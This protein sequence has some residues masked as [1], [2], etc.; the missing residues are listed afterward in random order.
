MHDAL[1]KRHL[2]FLRDDMLEHNLRR[3]IEP[4][5]CVD[6]TFVAKQISMELDRVEAKLAEM[7]LD[8]KLSGTLDQG[9]GTLIVF[10]EPAADDAYTSGLEAVSK[11]NGVVDQLMKRAEGLR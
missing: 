2:G 11:M 5:S 4:Y 10:E 8:K 6:L 3:I 7:I 1:L 9:R